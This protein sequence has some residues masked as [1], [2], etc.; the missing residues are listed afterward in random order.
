MPARTPSRAPLL[1]LSL[2]LAAG[3]AH[4]TLPPPSPQQ[5]A[6]AAQ[7]KAQADAQAQ[8]DKEKL[9]QSMDGIAARYRARAA[10]EG[11]TTHP[12]V[13]VAA[14]SAA[15][16]APAVATGMAPSKQPATGPVRSEKLGTAAPSAD[17][18]ARPTQAM[19]RGADP[20][21]NKSRHGK[22]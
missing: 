1:A 6:A 18:K 11:W 4:A 9:I 13:A 16:S 5:A 15:L 19:P 14:P 3:L 7:K 17:T 8:Q 12:P 10:R 2:L 22:Q 20:T 21:V